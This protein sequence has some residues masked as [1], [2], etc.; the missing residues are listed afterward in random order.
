MFRHPKSHPSEIWF[1]TRHLPPLNHSAAWS[2]RSISALFSATSMSANRYLRPP[3]SQLPLKRLHALQ[4]LRPYTT[5]SAMAKSK[6][7]FFLKHVDNSKF[8]NNS[9]LFDKVEWWDMSNT[10]VFFVK[11]ETGNNCW[12]HSRLMRKWNVERIYLNTIRNSNP[13]YWFSSNL[14]HVWYQVG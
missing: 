13:Q 8:W 12:L 2:L 6:P 11:L 10:D 5:N 3:C 7:R 1:A 4:L 9:Y 14:G